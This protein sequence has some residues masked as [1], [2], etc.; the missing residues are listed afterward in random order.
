MNK[1]ELP[2]YL[3]ETT[4]KGTLSSFW[5]KASFR[6]AAHNAAALALG[7]EDNLLPPCLTLGDSTLA[8]WAGE[9][10]VELLLVA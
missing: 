1:F 5:T 8:G 6:A 3:T 10:W 4:E 9:D 7:K 2:K